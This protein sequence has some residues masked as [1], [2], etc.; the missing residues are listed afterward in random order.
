MDVRD[1]HE[2]LERDAHLLPLG[3]LPDKGTRED[4]ASHV[5]GAGELAHALRA[6]QELLAVD[7]DRGPKEVRRVDQL[8]VHPLPGLEVALAEDA[9]HVDAAERL[10]RALLLLVEEAAAAEVAVAEGEDRVAPEAS[11]EVAN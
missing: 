6:L 2:A 5:E 10:D 8:A 1:A 7:L 9:G 3:A 4:T 11:S